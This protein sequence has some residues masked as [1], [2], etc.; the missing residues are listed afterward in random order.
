MRNIFTII[1][2]LFFSSQITA[3]DYSL[4]VNYGTGSGS[5]FYGDTV[6]VFS[7]KAPMI[8]VFTGWTGSGIDYLTIVDEWHTTL[9]LPSQS[10]VDNLVL[11]A[12]YDQL[13]MGTP[14]S[15]EM[16]SLFGEEGGTF[17]GNVMKEVHYVI[18]QN[19]KGIVFLFHGTGGNGGNMFSKYEPFTLIKDLYYAGYG[20]ISTDAN[21]RTLGDQDG[22]GKIRWAAS[23]AIQQ[24]FNNNIDLYN[25]RALKDTL[26]VRY[27]LPD[28]FPFFSYGVSNG[29]NFSDLA[30][31]AVGFQ[32]SAHNTGN[33]SSSLY[34]HR[35]DATPVI[36]LQALN[37][38]N[39][40]ADPAAALANYQALLDRGICSEWYW[41][42]RSPLFE[43]RFMRSRIGINQQESTSIYK[44]FFDYPNL[45]GHDGFIL[46]D[47]ILSEL[48]NDFYTP[49][50]LS[51]AQI[52]DAE[53]QMKAVNADHGATG[54]FNKTIIRFFENNCLTTPVNFLPDSPLNISL[55][56]NPTSD[57]VFLEA[58][59]ESLESATLFNLQGQVIKKYSFPKSTKK[60]ELNLSGIP[61][62]IYFIKIKWDGGEELKKV[63]FK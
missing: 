33:G 17:M 63:V 21:E 15:T 13:P 12:N 9:V 51:N 47:N 22:D 28:D 8:G 58:N 48:P 38:Q 6:H 53:S 30:A 31:A 41:L 27:D 56:P 20:S 4:T 61:S 26:V 18:P 39:S 35:P 46:V 25:V 1:T 36:W 42:D 14:Q 43:K 49:L 62:G 60:Y 5:Y 3:Q 44:R 52:N 19:P 11:N 34:L 55:F 45:V 37:D 10:G 50:G 29:A 32:A 54:D 24:N 40:S 16:I 7:D 59:S 2:L 23:Q 57:F